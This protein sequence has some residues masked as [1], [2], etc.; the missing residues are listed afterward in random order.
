MLA[1]RCKG[2]LNP[3]LTFSPNALGS[4]LGIQVFYLFIYLFIYLIH[5]YTI[6]VTIVTIEESV[7]SHYRL[8]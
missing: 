2:C 5:E 7:R 6:A 3:F 4:K 8:L 1:G